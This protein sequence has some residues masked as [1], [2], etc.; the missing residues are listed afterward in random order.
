MLTLKGSYNQ[1][2]KNLIIIFSLA[3]ELLSDRDLSLR[4][5]INLLGQ[6]SGYFCITSDMVHGVIQRLAKAEV[7]SKVE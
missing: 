7:N 6:Y 2:E 4:K 3:I 1:G 5:S